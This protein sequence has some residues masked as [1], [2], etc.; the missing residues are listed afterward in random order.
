[1]DEVFQINHQNKIDFE[2][3]PGYMKETIKKM[4]KLHKKNIKPNKSIYH[5][6]IM[7]ETIHE[8]IKTIKVEDYIII[9]EF[10][11]RFKGVKISNKDSGKVLTEWSITTK[12]V[13]YT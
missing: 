7:E 11:N 3:F 8:D 1:M 6:I 2:D 4:F 13:M 10:F 5:R 9:T 12:S